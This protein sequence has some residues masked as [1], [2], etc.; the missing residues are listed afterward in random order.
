MQSLLGYVNAGYEIIAQG[1]EA[2]VG[3]NKNI[4]MYVAWN[5]SI[6]NGEP[7]FY[8]GRYGLLKEEAVEAFRKKEIGVYSGS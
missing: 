6:R 8:W 1:E 3:Y 5:Y 4:N 7:D 2:V